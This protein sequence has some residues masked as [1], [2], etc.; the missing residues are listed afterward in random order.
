PEGVFYLYEIDINNQPP[1]F[2]RLKL[3]P[4]WIKV[5]IAIIA[6]L[7]LSF[8]FSRNLIAPI[9]SLKK[10]AIKLSSG[11]LSARAAISTNRKD[12][13]GVLGRDFN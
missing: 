7:I 5:S 8:L 6:S 3:M 11:D 12:E 9:N 4:G 10:A 2:I 13:L 1:L